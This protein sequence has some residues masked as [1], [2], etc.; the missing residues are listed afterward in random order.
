MGELRRKPIFFSH[1][2]FHAFKVQDK[3][4][5]G[6]QRTIELVIE[7]KDKINIY[8]FFSAEEHLKL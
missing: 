3:F 6:I 2:Q 4:A 7:P 1:P 8:I 5:C